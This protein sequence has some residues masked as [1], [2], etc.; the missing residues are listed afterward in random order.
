VTDFAGMLHMA[1][2][3]TDAGPAFVDSY[4]RAR[5]G[6]RWGFLPSQLGHKT[7]PAYL[8]QQ[9]MGARFHTELPSLEKVPTSLLRCSGTP[10]AVEREVLRSHLW[11]C[12]REGGLKRDEFSPSC[13]KVRRS[14][15]YRASPCKYR[16]SF[17]GWSG[18][19]QRLPKKKSVGMYL[20]PA[21]YVSEEEV[22]GLDEL[23][24]WHQAF[25]SLAV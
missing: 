1:K 5:I 11:G 18:R 19:G 8:R 6:R 10:G 4:Q 17:V 15:G 2:A 22:R 9:G 13:G 16:L 20:V 7:Y 25:G 23:D 24:L 21:S 3:V 14:Y 12:G